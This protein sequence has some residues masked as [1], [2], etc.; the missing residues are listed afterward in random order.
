MKILT[1]TINN[2]NDARAI[3][4][5]LSQFIFRGQEDATWDLKTTIQ[6]GDLKL[7]QL[8]ACEDQMIDVFRRRAHHFL[9]DPPPEGELLEWIALIQHFGGPTR[10]LDF[11]RS[12]Y[13]AAFFAVEKTV[14]DSAIWCVNSSALLQSFG[15]KYGEGKLLSANLPHWGIP[16]ILRGLMQDL[17]KQ[18]FSGR[19]LVCEVEPFRLNERLAIQQGVF[20]GPAS[21]D[22]PFMQSLAQTFDCDGISETSS[23]PSEIYRADVHTR[24]RLNEAHVIKIVLPIKTHLET[25]QD[26]W[27]MNVTAASLFPGLDG[28]A[29]SLHYFIQK[30]RLQVR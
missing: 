10:L 19:G 2:W 4:N 27:S 15:R 21:I 11:T 24:E 30:E 8:N 17:I 13:I 3:A 20:L 23:G 28:F 6:R 22:L 7:A 14:K 26:L 16:N 1:L 5:D 12:F 25:L 9:H 18:K 29:R